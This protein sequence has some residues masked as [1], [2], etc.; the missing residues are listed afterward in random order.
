MARGLTLD[1]CAISGYLKDGKIMIANAKEKSLTKE[2]STTGAP[3]GS[4][5]GPRL[6]I[7]LANY[8]Q[9]VVFSGNSHYMQTI[10]P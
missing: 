8:L 10:P 6:Y 1:K 9:N 7:L 5:L 3:Q 2:L 4:F